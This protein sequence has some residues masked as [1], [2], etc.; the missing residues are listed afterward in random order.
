MSNILGNMPPAFGSGTRGVVPAPTAA[1]VA[2]QNI[3]RADGTWGAAPGGSLPS[4][5][6]N[7]GKILTTDGTNASWSS[8]IAGNLT[9]SGGTTQIGSGASALY[10]KTSAFGSDFAILT[11][12]GTFSAGNYAL[13]TSAASKLTSLNAPTGGT[14]SLGIGNSQSFT[15]NA[16][17]NATVGGNLT[18]SGGTAT[19]S[20]AT[21]ADLYVSKTG[22][23]ALSAYFYNQGTGSGGFGLYDG[24]APRAVWE[25]S[26]AA[27]DFNI[28]TSSLSVNGRM[29]VNG[30]RVDNHN[31]S[32]NL[33]SDIPG[34]SFQTKSAGS[35]RDFAITNNYSGAGLLEFLSSSTAQG[36]PNTSLLA[37]TATGNLLLGTTT[38]NTLGKLQVA[39]GATFDYGTNNAKQ[40][41][42][43]NGDDPTITH[44]KWSGSGSTYL[45]TRIESQGDGVAPY[46]GKMLFQTATAPAAVGSETFATA[47]TLDSSQNATFAGTVKVTNKLTAPTDLQIEAGGSG[48]VALRV[49]SFGEI[50]RYTSQGNYGFNTSSEFGSGAGVI[51][52]KSAVTSPTTNPTGGGVLYVE[53]G[54]LKYRGSS[55]TVTTIANA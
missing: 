36:L 44:Y 35:N 32:A 25:Y 1:D 39:G 18:V 13:A 47:L 23:S 29:T 43:K 16:G 30:N 11:Q 6:S 48:V 12:D 51:A 2:A 33:Y 54:A 3:L 40:Y 31:L 45:A 15:I 34:I 22:T 19:V 28:K 9:V 27:N 7:A 14:V 42:T 20:S 5:T 52:I 17:G 26:S 38:D 10:A 53:G 46:G 37:L 4:Q 8:A 24:T 41:L 49:A 21:E 55:G 50:A